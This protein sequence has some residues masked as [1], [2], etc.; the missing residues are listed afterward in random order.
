MLSPERAGLTAD[1]DEEQS[2]PGPD[3]AG[4]PAEN[5]EQQ[6]MLSPERA[7]CGEHSH[8]NVCIKTITEHINVNVGP[9][10]AYLRERFGE[11]NHGFYHKLQKICARPEIWLAAALEVFVAMQRP[12]NPP[13]HPGKYFFSR[14]CDMHQHGISPIAQDL[15]ARYGDLSYAQLV[16]TLHASAS[17]PGQTPRP[18]PRSAGQA[19]FE[20]RL[21][22]NREICGMP[23]EDLDAL[24]QAISE[25][26]EWSGWISRRYRQAD[27][28][29]ALLVES[30][31][32]RQIWLYSREHWRQRLM[33][34]L[35]APQQADLRPS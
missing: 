16:E 23:Q 34:L 6:S 28:S 15:I 1:A 8:V 25:Q 17:K 12:A 13:H 27:G 29:C 2:R 21:E 31:L 30:S 11:S 4:S 19:P 5:P 22:R 26:V 18:R 3:M 20:L 35:P 32:R 33:T 9:V 10:S 14:V 24:Q 7:G